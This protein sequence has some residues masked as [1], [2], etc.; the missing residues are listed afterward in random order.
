MK[1]FRHPILA[2]LPARALFGVVR[3]DVLYSLV[4]PQLVNDDNALSWSGTRSITCD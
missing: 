3:A 4:G 2:A 1:S